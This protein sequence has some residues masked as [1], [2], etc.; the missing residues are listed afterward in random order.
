VGIQLVAIFFTFFRVG[1]ISA[2]I[3]IVAAL[4][5]RPRRYGRAIATLAIAL[6]VL[7]LA[8]SQLERIPAVSNRVGNTENISTRFATYEQGW[9]IF[10]D[11]PLVGVGVTRYNAVASELP[12]RSVGGSRSQPYAHS[13]FLGVMAEDGVVGLIALV[14]AFA[15][16]AALVRALNRA[17][18]SRPDAVLVAALAGAAVSY[19]IYS[20]TLTMLPYSPSNEL[21]AML[22]GL[23]AGRLDFLTGRRAA[24]S[25]ARSDPIMP[26]AVPPN[27][28]RIKIS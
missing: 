17:T 23:A 15:A 12:T 1:W 4:G 19:L 3:V 14:L 10:V 7:T 5:L 11:H 2:A 28:R 13:S 27:P 6:L 9:G 22:L 20:V 25:Q 8:F 21:M 26:T 24:P 16:A 18:R